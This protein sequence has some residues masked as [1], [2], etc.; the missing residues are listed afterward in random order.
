[1]S[2][3]IGLVGLLLF[4]SGACAL[5]YQTVWL[6]QFR[7]IF[8]ASTAASAAVLAIFMAGLGIGGLLLGP[9]ADR[10]PRPLAFY[11]MLELGVALS[12]AATPLLLL[13]VRWI[14]L[15]TG[16]SATLGLP[17][18]TLLRLVLATVVLILPTFLMGG[19]LPAAARAITAREDVGRRG[20]S[21]LYGVNT[22]GAVSGV[23][24]STFV[25]LELFGNRMTLFFAALLNVLLALGALLIDRRDSSES[26][27]AAIDE[28]P[29][30]ASVAPRRFVLVASAAVGFTFLLMELVWYRMLA[31]L[32]GGTT[33][34]FGLI[35]AIALLGIG[36][37]GLFYALRENR[38]ATIGAFALSCALEALFLALP[39]AWGDGLAMMAMLIRPV[40]GG[41]GFPGYVI[42]WTIVTF[43]V[44][45]PAAFIAGLQFP[46]LISL[47]GRGRESVARDIGLTYAWNTAGSIA[48]SIAG[49]FGALPLLSAPGT[50]RLSVW[51]LVVVTGG[52]IGVALARTR[53]SWKAAVAVLV[54]ACAI[55]ATRA[56]GPTAA[57]RHTPI[58]AGRAELAKPTRNRVKEF[59]HAR[60]R[61]IEW[62]VD[63]VES[64]LALSKND[65]Y[66]F[67]VNG[68]SDGHAILDGGT[69]IMG[70]ILGTALH[71]NAKNALVIGLGTGTTAG[72]LGAVPELERVDVFEIEPAIER[73]AA[74]C[75]DVNHHPLENR[76]VH[77]TYGDARE[78]LLTSKRRYDVISSEPSNPYRSGI[79]S[80]LT[81]DFY[82]SAKSRLAPGGIFLQF[83]QAYEIDSATL[84]MVYATFGTVFPN[85][86]TWETRRGDLLLVGTVEPIRYD[87][88]TL[89]A[90]FARDPYRSAILAVWRAT[91]LEGVLAH[92]VA[93]PSTSQALADGALTNTDD[94]TRIEYGFARTLG[95]N[96]YFQINDLRELSR[97]KLDDLP[98]VAGAVNVTS[99]RD[100]RLSLIASEAAFP[101]EM[102]T[103]NPDQQLRVRAYIAH[104]QGDYEGALRAWVGQRSRPTAPT[105]LL[106]FAESY[107]DR[108]DDAV[109]PYTQELRAYKP[110]EADYV[111]ARLRWRQKRFDEAA[112]A[113][114][115]CLLK[116][117]RDAWMMPI[118]QE[119]VL[120]LAVDIGVAN[121]AAGRVLY[122]I[123]GTP[124]AAHAA[125]GQR[126]LT[127]LQIA[128][129][130]SGGQ[131]NELAIQALEPFEKA[132][133]W[134]RFFLKSRVT[135]YEK[136]NHPRL[137]QARKD[138]EEFLHNEPLSLSATVH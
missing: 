81:T 89:R 3:R 70:G 56:T 45:F 114:R 94:R 2:R 77:I 55:V 32:L 123:L 88:A 20:L 38:E 120:E 24:L 47:L 5:M 1:M 67:V 34:T 14:Y 49:G 100:Q 104:A 128:T 87:A 72:W 116:M 28:A 102:G 111:V 109:L 103:L 61:T 64:S 10:H 60:I 83:L 36:A 59:I 90:K 78:L 53:L 62:D 4:G 80:L 12:A 8:G 27:P 71:R 76:N 112:A 105:D 51:V 69:Q 41:L 101:P 11:G 65:G 46:L 50:W 17:F 92:Y 68:K 99:V 19:T 79:A 107:S 113:M 33:F 121:P 122:E 7:L 66:A 37:G 58:G 42:G 136:F 73:V 135:C 15:A 97:K 131:C 57:W 98:P 63:G 93:G 110:A 129:N 22:L 91:D 16:G 134:D 9:R 119:R 125:D 137:A 54:A 25:L 75:N 31:P 6:R 127:R 124:F 39:F 126:L 108:G 26:D 95:N 117:Q 52:A 21:V 29:R 23:V 85:V 115:A 13:L 106:T 132:V 82:E 118:L 30:A 44:V 130:L 96:A 40:G 48:G 43:I 18:A 133:P 74:A 84:R 138:W 35:L 86:E